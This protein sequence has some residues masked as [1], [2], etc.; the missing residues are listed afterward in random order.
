MCILIN[1]NCFIPPSFQVVGATLAREGYLGYTRRPAT[2][3]VSTS[4]AMAAVT[5]LSGGVLVANGVGVWEVAA[6][7]SSQFSHHS[8]LILYQL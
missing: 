8:P 1:F 4:R 7:S 2:A 6:V 3:V 5:P